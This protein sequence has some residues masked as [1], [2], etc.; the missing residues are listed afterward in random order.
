MLLS[1]DPGLQDAKARRLLALTG[2]AGWGC[3]AATANLQQISTISSL[4]TQ[5]LLGFNTKADKLHDRNK[6]SSSRDTELSLP[7]LDKMKTH[8]WSLIRAFRIG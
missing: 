3:R 1:S 7:S 2:D 6:N 4:G 8:F 5:E